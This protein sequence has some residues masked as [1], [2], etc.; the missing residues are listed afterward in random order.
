[1]AMNLASA[2]R[3][4]Q[5]EAPAP[6]PSA[7]PAL[8]FNLRG[9]ELEYRE[10][11]HTARPL[12]GIDLEIPRGQFVCILGPSG[13][14]KS[15]LLRCL[16]GLLEPT[17]GQ[18]LADGRQVTGPGADR[19]MVFQN[20]AIPMWLRVEDNVAF[21]PR[22]RGQKS[23]RYA[24]RVDHFIEEV[25]LSGHRRAWPRQLS[26]GMRKRVAIAAVFANDPAVLLMD[27]PFGALDFITRSKLHRL[28]TKLWQETGKTICFVTH[29]IDEALVLADRIIVL[30]QGTIALDE[31]VDF[32]RPR[33]E[34][35]RSSPEANALRDRLLAILAAEESR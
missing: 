7:S 11:H 15:T 34:E 17:G 6:A 25:G 22:S 23:S 1:M 33:G 2:T 4:L 3:S 26:G 14:G 13:Q 27:E 9:L 20:D 30:N 21:G 18:L 16:A 5:Y 8:A 12:D 28:V 32:A 24:D 35:L 31:M 10:G 19:G 29:D